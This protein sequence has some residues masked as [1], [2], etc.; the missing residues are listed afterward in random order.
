MVLRTYQ[1]QET[2]SRKG[3]RLTEIYAV[4]LHPGGNVSGERVYKCSSPLRA[5]RF[6]AIAE[7]VRRGYLLDCYNLE[8]G[9]VSYTYTTYGVLKSI[10]G[11][12]EERERWGL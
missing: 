5:S 4:R 8:S 10:G 2:D 3:K 6:A 12:R 11:K 1:I 7:A 9:R